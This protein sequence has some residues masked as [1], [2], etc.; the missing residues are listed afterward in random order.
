MPYTALKLRKETV[1][2]TIISN[3][4]SGSKAKASIADSRFLFV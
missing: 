4:R 1:L 3:A 2:A